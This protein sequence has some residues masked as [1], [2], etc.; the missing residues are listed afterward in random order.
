MHPPPC[1]NIYLASDDAWFCQRLWHHLV[2]ND[3]LEL[4]GALRDRQT[5]FA[6][7]VPVK[8]FKLYIF[9]LEILLLGADQEKEAMDLARSLEKRTLPLKK[10]HF[11]QHE[12]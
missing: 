8:F 6:L 9:F 10:V 7:A 2:V 3:L 11:T 1:T 4:L 5:S 12:H